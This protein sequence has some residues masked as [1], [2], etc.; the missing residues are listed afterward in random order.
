[1]SIEKLLNSVFVVI[2]PKVF[3]VRHQALGIVFQ[4]STIKM[5]FAYLV[6]L[7]LNNTNLQ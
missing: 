4:L 2:K 5:Q 6:K 3:G 1:M 7:N